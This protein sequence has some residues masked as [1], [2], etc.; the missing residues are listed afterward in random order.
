MNKLTSFS[1]I[2]TECSMNIFLLFF[3]TLKTYEGMSFHFYFHTGPVEDKRT[4]KTKFLTNNEQ[5]EISHI[6][7]KHNTM[8]TFQRR[9]SYT[10]SHLE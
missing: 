6:K 2:F 4:H 7:I 5:F 9:M 3:K 8:Q 10:I 1:K